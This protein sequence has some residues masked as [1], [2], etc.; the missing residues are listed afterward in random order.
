MSDYESAR[1]NAKFHRRRCPHCNA[2]QFQK[3]VKATNPNLRKCVTCKGL[4]DLI[5][6]AVVPVERV[7]KHA[8]EKS[9]VIPVPCREREFRPLKRD[10]FEFMRLAMVIR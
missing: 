10:P 9:G 3:V 8:P 2:G 5:T 6:E 1:P 7:S 4:F